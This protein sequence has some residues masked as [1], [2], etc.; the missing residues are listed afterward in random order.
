MDGFEPQLVAQMA[1]KLNEVGPEINKM[2]YYWSRY[3]PDAATLKNML[4]S[5]KTKLVENMS[6]AQRLHWFSS[7]NGNN[8]QDSDIINFV[9]MSLMLMFLFRMLHDLFR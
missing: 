9:K 3:K 4:I 8:I 2:A 6:P 7:S 5:N 1:A